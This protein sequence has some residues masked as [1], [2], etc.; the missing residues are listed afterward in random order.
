MFKEKDIEIEQRGGF[1]NN[2]KLIY[3]NKDS[4]PKIN[5]I[6]KLYRIDSNKIN[7]D[8]IKYYSEQFLKSKEMFDTNNYLKTKN[9]LFDRICKLHLL[10]YNSSYI[11]CT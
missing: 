3:S 7:K 4:D 8:H 9:G 5:I 10:I 1:N 11:K 6:T 2:K